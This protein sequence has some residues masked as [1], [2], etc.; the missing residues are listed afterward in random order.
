MLLMKGMR[1]YMAEVTVCCGTVQ[2]CCSMLVSV[3]SNLALPN[4]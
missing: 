3:L 2:L 4:R 1:M